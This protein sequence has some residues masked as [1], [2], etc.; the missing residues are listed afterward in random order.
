MDTLALQTSAH[1]MIV[2]NGGTGQLVR[3]GVGRDATMARME[4]SPRERG[5]YADKTARMRV[6]AIGLAQADGPDF[7]RDQITY[8]GVTYNILLPA[9][10]PRV[11]NEFIYWDCNV[12]EASE[13]E[14]S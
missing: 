8:L 14:A 4:Y 1:N 5:L 11:R 9:E 10:G 7:E 6:S 3:N 13:R 12:T 2:D